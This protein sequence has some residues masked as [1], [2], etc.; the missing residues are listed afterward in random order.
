MIIGY[1]EAK[2]SEMIDENNPFYGKIVLTKTYREETQMDKWVNVPEVESGCHVILKSKLSVDITYDIR[3][4]KF[5]FTTDD[6]EVYADIQ[7]GESVIRVYCQFDGRF[8]KAEQWFDYGDFTDALE[9][10]FIWKSND[11]KILLKETFLS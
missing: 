3:I 2:V 5:A 6:D 11:E 10:N 9:P 1:T 4:N 7:I 8:I